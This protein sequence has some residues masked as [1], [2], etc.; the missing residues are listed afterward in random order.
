MSQGSIVIQ[1]SVDCNSTGACDPVMFQQAFANDTIAAQAGD[2]VVF[3]RIANIS[4]KKRSKRDESQLVCPHMGSFMPHALHLSEP[5]LPDCMKG[6]AD[7]ASADMSGRDDGRCPCPLDQGQSSHACET[8]Y[9]AGKMRVLPSLDDMHPLPP[10][11]K[12]YGAG[13]TSSRR[14]VWISCSK[15]AY[16]KSEQS[17]K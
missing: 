14:S 8:Y 10:T 7:V 1:L 15:F 13:E 11:R 2:T 5:S 17:E 6:A 16:T 12:R 3:D 4:V 9:T